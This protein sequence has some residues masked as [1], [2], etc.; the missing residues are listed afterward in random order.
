MKNLPSQSR[1]SRHIK[2]RKGLD[3]PIGGAP[4]QQIAE[5]TL[6]IRHVAVV[7]VDF[8]DLKPDMRVAEG[9]QVRL[10]QVLF[11]HRKL[12]EVVFTALGGGQIEAIHR[13]ERRRLLSVI[14]RLNQQETEE[15][16]SQYAPEA[17]STLTADQVKANLLS[18]GLW[19]ALRTRPFSKIPDPA[20]RPAA[21]FITAMDTNPLAADPAL[22]I[23]AEA[24]AFGHGMQV[25]AQLT[26]GPLWLCHD[27]KSILPLSATMTLSIPQLQSVAFSGP[28]PAGLPGTHIH[29]LQPADLKTTVWHLNYQD[30]IAIG[31][32]FTTGRLAVER[33]VA[34][35]GPPV[36]HPRL[37]RTRMGA[38]IQELLASE[39]IDG[40]ENRIIS[41]SVWSGR[42][43]V[44]EL[45][46]LGRYHLQISAI[47]EAPPREFLGWLRP[48]GNKFSRMNVF[49]SSLLRKRKVY[50]F[51][52]SQHGSPRAMIPISTFE[53]VMPLDMLPTQLLRALLV[54]D[55]DMAQKLGCL[56]LDEEDL[57]LCSFVCVGK[58]DYGVVLRNNLRLIEKEG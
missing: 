53:E 8:V 25:L 38:S 9:D 6:S 45:A 13:G 49:F 44:G 54:A 15:T 22:I 39:G 33:I 34:L 24:A 14:I 16:F 20:T 58:H 36:A 41:G 28:H 10:G 3:L 47:R 21:L 46:Y 23:A 52:A 5:G 42:R 43:A 7:G 19:T 17:L 35:G 29:F 51:S 48:D 12:P 56:E 27:V 50:E 32:L 11:S 57:A 18:S 55:T 26:D 31:K 1:E 40:N 4:Q 30:V 37:L 2:L